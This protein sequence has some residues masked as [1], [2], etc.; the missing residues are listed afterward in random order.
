MEYFFLAD[1]KPLHFFNTSVHHEYTILPHF[2]ISEAMVY[3][4]DKEIM[5]NVLRKTFPRNEER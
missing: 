2:E 3:T 1:D 5:G 4:Y